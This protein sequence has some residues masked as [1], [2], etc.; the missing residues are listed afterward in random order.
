[1]RRLLRRGNTPAPMLLGLLGVGISASVA[2]HL[3]AQPLLA[4]T[5]AGSLTCP[6]AEDRR[7]L[8]RP[9]AAERT[10]PPAA[11]AVASD[12]R[13][14]LRPTYRGWPRRDHW[15]LWIEPGA[16][17]GPA[18]RWDG[19][20]RQAVQ[21]ALNTWS[22]ELPITLVD[23]PRQAQIQLLRRRPPLRGGR[24]SHG[25]AELQLV[26]V[27]RQGN[28]QLEPE[29]LVSISPGQRLEATQATALHELGHAFGLWGHSDVAGDAL[30][31]IP[32]PVPVLELSERD[33]ATLRWLQ[34]QPGLSQPPPAA[35]APAAGPAEMP[36]AAG[37]PHTVLR[38]D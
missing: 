2:R 1:M 17:T 27:L 30:A 6:V 19:S 16:T 31:A 11:P 33:R 22:A 23:D 10:P 32:G 12:Y 18:A 9:T 14:L 26:A 7:L 29:V 3:L 35:T 21:A 38:A 20:W 13:H 5:P 24:A 34:A 4:A 28:W 8:P 37:S 15:C 25:R 36:A